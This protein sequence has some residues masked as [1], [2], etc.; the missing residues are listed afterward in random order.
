MLHIPASPLSNTAAEAKTNPGSCNERKAP[1]DTSGSAAGKGVFLNQPG[2]CAGFDR[3]SIAN[4]DK[5]AGFSEQFQKSV[6]VLA[7]V[8]VSECYSLR[9]RQVIPGFVGPE[10]FLHQDV[11]ER[12][13]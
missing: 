10:S 12:D 2:W 3:F 7:K 8:P 4:R 13:S 6:S 11:F 5:G 1:S 9:H